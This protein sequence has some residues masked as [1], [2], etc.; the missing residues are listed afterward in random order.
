MLLKRIIQIFFLLILSFNIFSCATILKGTS[1][2]I[3]IKSEPEQAEVYVNY[4]LI[5]ETPITLNLDYKNEYWIDIKKE[6][7]QTYH[8]KMNKKFQFGWLIIDLVNP[9][10]YYTIPADLGTGAWFKFTPKEIDIK[11]DINEEP[12][13]VSY[14]NYRLKSKYLDIKIY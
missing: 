12:E 13:T 14:N 6:G 4:K 2:N 3:Y 10:F 1:Q 7:Y 11:L 8:I 5:G 9:F